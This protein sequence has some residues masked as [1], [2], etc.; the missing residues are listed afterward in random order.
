MKRILLLASLLISVFAL[1]A[2]DTVRYGDPWYAFNPMSHIYP[3]D[4][5]DSWGLSSGYFL[6]SSAP[7]L[8]G[9]HC[10]VFAD[11][12]LSLDAGFF[13]Q[14]Y[15]AYTN[16]NY[17]IY[18]IALTTQGLPDSV[19][20]PE[21][22]LI[23]GFYYHSVYTPFLF[24]PDT[25]AFDPSYIHIDSI[26]QIDTLNIWQAL[27]KQCYFDY[28]FGYDFPTQTSLK[29]D[30]VFTSNCYEFFFDNPI[31]LKS[32]DV[33]ATVGSGILDTFFIGGQYCSIDTF[34][35]GRLI[36]NGFDSARQQPWLIMMDTTF[37]MC[38]DYGWNAS[39][40]TLSPL[41]Y[42]AYGSSKTA[43]G[44]VFPIIKLR[45]VEPKLR[46]VT[47]VNRTAT[48]AWRQ[49]DTPEQY[50]LS[51]TPWD[52]AGTDPDSGAMYYTTDTSFT[53]T[54]LQ[55]DTR[56][57]VWVRKAC[58]YT[59][60]AYDTI[61]WSDWSNEIVFMFVD[62]DEVEADG[63]RIT[64]QRGSIVV[65]GAEGREVRVYDML[66]REVCGKRKVESGKSSFTVP[67]AGI[68]MVRVG[69]LPARKV[70]VLR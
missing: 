39:F 9:N 38:N 48:V 62:I 28:H 1:R 35:D 22:L 8:F 36:M 53:F 12:H 13:I 55:P 42:N 7:I 25:G 66:G 69:D 46:F 15:Q 59:T 37:E 2:Q 20:V 11:R 65:E 54:D 24:S 43:W 63:V 68:Y 30:S 3:P 49:N 21:L 61:V 51:I 6:G 52:I 29:N 67:V 56:Y 60:S 17:T 57:S 18:G 5:Y 40:S 50:Q 70:A 31:S 23:H 41:Y 64:S 4:I 33:G 58:R 16:N 10:G 32:G 45:C 27:M 26:G 34:F 44:V 19:M 47:K 14:E